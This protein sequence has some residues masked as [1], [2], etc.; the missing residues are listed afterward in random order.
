MDKY[1]LDLLEDLR[2]RIATNSGQGPTGNSAKAN[3][4]PFKFKKKDVPSL[5]QYIQSDECRKI[6]LMVFIIR[7]LV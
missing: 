4:K 1:G 6:Y 3:S 7:K 5:A 2:A